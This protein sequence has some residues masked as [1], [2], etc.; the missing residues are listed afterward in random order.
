MSQ[1]YCMKKYPFEEVV[2][3]LTL[4]MIVTLDSLALLN[5]VAGMDHLVLNSLD[6]SAQQLSH[7]DALPHLVGGHDALALAAVN[8]VARLL[9]SRVAH[10]Q[11]RKPKLLTTYSNL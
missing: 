8:V 4:S 6:Q 10:L 7:V 9:V 2:E 3:L 11:P 1:K 5:G